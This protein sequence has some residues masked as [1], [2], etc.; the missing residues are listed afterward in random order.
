MVETGTVVLGTVIAY[1]LLVL[2]VG[3]YAR[4]ATTL[5]RE[6]FFMANRSFGTIVL[7][8]ALLAT[9]M[10]AFVMIGAPGLAYRAGVG[11][12]GYVNGIFT[13]VFP[14]MLA[15]VGYRLWLTG[16]RFS[17][18]TP[19]EMFNHRFESRHLGTFIMALMI[20]WTVP[21]IL[22]GAIGGGLAFN[23]LTA[24]AV[25]Y[26]AGSFIV[27][28]IV[29]VY[30]LSG[31][32]RGTAWTNTFQ[33][34]VFI[35]FLWGLVIYLGVRLG[36]F[37]AA[38]QAT[39]DQAP[40]LASRAGPP[41]FDTKHWLSFSLVLALDA[42]MFPHLFRRVLTGLSEDVLKRTTLL[43]PIGL[44]LVWVPP[45]IVGFWGAGQITGLAGAEADQILP[46][47]VGNFT[48]ALLAGLGLAGIL[49]AIMS[50]ID[51]QTLTVSTL[52]TEDLIHNYYEDI[53][54]RRE[55]FLARA[56]V[57]LLL[58][59][60]FVLSLIQPG[61]IVGI[62]EFAFSGY[63]LLFFP[64]IVAMYWRGATEAGAW[65]G[66]AWGFIGLW[67]FELGVIPQS[68]TFGFM[69]FMPVFVVQVALV[70][71]VGYLT[72]PPSAERVREYFRLYDGVW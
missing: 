8:F 9:N 60:A 51:G 48:P 12:Y 61:T 47:M 6:D 56:F 37:T 30:V 34:A 63:A 69:P 64:M 50:S 58:A 1:L 31:G 44:L 27:L 62:A 15:T 24:G 4:R 23:G 5:D 13:L 36:G 40:Q 22:L 35:V 7:L 11:A 16:K 53:N 38:T 26:W 43:Y 21:Y 57:V 29:F 28:A 45:V 71:A 72:S 41:P 18:I 20:F 2:G 19:G 14:L 59:A 67:L 52:L 54:E 39:M 49:A 70:L 46:A 3:E 55:V 65:I 66:L 32:M 25:P 17:H 68:L 10:T 42:L 33:G